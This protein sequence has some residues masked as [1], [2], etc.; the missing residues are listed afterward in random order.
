MQSESRQRYSHSRI[1]NDDKYEKLI[2]EVSV[3]AKEGRNAFKCIHCKAKFKSKQWLNYHCLK[4]CDRALDINGKP[5]ELKLYPSVTPGGAAEVRD[6][7]EKHNLQIRNAFN[8]IHCNKEC[9]SKYQLNYHCSMGVLVFLASMANLCSS[10]YFHL[11]HLE[12]L[13]KSGIF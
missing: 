11:C 8:C 6:I 10:N 13:L 3:S 7:L 12:E 2:Y 4:G 1:F 9:A 5:L